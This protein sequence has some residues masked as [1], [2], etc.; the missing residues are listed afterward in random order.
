MCDFKKDFL[1]NYL[2]FGLGS[3]S[4]T[5]IDALVMHLLDLYG[6]QDGKS[7]MQKS[8]QEVSQML[9]TPVAK[10]KKLRYEAALKYGGSIEDNARGRLLAAI[11]NATFEWDSKK[12]H[13]I[14]ED[15]LAKSWLQGQ[16]KK[17]QLIFDNSFNTEIIKVD[18]E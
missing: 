14:I 10:V 16:L 2:R 9:R 6:A 5:D 3:L 17:H 4:K 1:E 11:A 12:I 7:L 13:L 18:A 15:T 8:N